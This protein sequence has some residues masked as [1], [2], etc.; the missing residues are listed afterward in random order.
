MKSGD[1]QLKEEASKVLA[2]LFRGDV[3]S[4]FV[5]EDAGVPTDELTV[6]WGT[7]S[8][9]N[10]W[11]SALNEVE[12]GLIPPERLKDCPLADGVLAL[13]LAALNRFP[14]NRDLPDLIDRRE[15]YLVETTDRLPPP[16]LKVLF[17][18]ANPTDTA[19]LRIGKE[20]QTL[21]KLLAQPNLPVRIKLVPVWGVEPP[22]VQGAIL[23]NRPDLVHFSGHGEHDGILLES[24]GSGNKV[25]LS[26][27]LLGK[28]FAEINRP[29]KQR[30]V[31]CVVLN[32]C[33]SGP[34]AVAVSHSVD[35]VVGTREAIA[36]DA[37]VAFVREFYTGIARG[38]SVD[39]AVGL[40]RNGMEMA[41]S[42]GFFDPKL[43]VV[44]HMKRV[45][46]DRLVLARA[47]TSVG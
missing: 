18:A 45:N 15:E 28:V 4:R 42:G 27:G 41:G 25:A 3:A 46:L 26:P 35:A 40:G 21:E 32:A 30:R 12:K 23:D 44:H 1:E 39:N 38:R 10:F 5:L 33:H 29:L 7:V 17:L 47:E 20:F 34:V 6:Q 11:T 8:P 37:A 2:G 19:V 24:P 14:G 36:D 31:R 13:F 16:S 43:V 9:R 22:I